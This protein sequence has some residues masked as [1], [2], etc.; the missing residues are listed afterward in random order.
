MRLATS[1]PVP[2]SQ[3]AFHRRLVYSIRPILT[4]RQVANP[5]HPVYLNSIHNFE[6]GNF[7]PSGERRR[8]RYATITI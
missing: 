6:A 8:Q 2:P 3:K 1:E 4:P 5:A 7:C